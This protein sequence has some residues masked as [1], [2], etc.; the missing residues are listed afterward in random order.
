MPILD[1]GVDDGIAFLVMNYTPYGTLRQH[2]PKGTRVPLETVLGY[3]R[4]LSGALTYVHQQGL[5]HRDIKPHNMLLNEQGEVMLSDFGTAVGSYSLNPGRAHVQNFEGT[6][7]YSAPEQL[8]GRSRRSSDQYALAIVVYEWLS[9]DWPFSGT[10]H[11]TAH[12]HLFV[13]PPPFREKGLMLPA[14]IEQVILRALEKSPDKRFPSIKLFADELEWAYKVAQAK[15]QVQL[16]TTPPP[17]Q[18]EQSPPA[19][20]TP[21]PQMVQ[22]PKRQFKAPFSPQNKAK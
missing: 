14:N 8:Q 12:Q 6:V 21:L 19:L 11:E 9:G 16:P 3:V 2:H 13:P 5:V 10:F 20:E 15:G 4:Q 22:A 7:L 1:F 17:V 18:I